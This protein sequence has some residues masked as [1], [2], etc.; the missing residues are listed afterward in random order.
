MQDGSHLYVPRRSVCDWD[1]N[2][3]KQPKLFLRANQAINVASKL[4]IERI[5]Y[6]LTFDPLKK[7]FRRKQSIF[8]NQ[9]LDPGRKR[10]NRQHISD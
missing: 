5:S 2:W 4:K 3:I 9:N 10:F 1:Q 7:S 8:V 6:N